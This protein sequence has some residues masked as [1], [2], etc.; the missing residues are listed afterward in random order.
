MVESAIMRESREP[1]HEP[2]RWMTDQAAGLRRMFAN[3]TPQVIAFTA[4]KVASGRTTLLT[5][6][7]SALAVMGR[8]VLIIDENPAP[9][10]TLARFGLKPR[11][12]LSQVLRDECS[13][14][15]AVLEAAPGLRILAAT[16][17]AQVLEQADRHSARAHQRLQTCLQMLQRDFEFILIDTAIS[18]YR[19]LSALTLSAQHLAIVVGAQSTAITQAYALIKRLHQERGRDGFQLIISRA[20]SHQ[21]AN[22]IFS[23][24][25]QLASTRLDIRL[26]HLG[27]VLVPAQEHLA[28]ALLHRLPQA[29]QARLHTPAS[30]SSTETAAQSTRLLA[31]SPLKRANSMV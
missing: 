14:D 4:G 24:I 28:Q 25:S 10:N 13:L 16:R 18:S 27:T 15:Q 1:A 8:Q 23:N 22:A 6:T 31:G 9:A 20:R 29:S 7:A 30:A 5:Q 11:Q 21:E 17:A 3:P 26:N 19:P 12:D 2:P